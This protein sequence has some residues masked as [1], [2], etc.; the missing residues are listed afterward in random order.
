MILTSKNPTECQNAVVLLRKTGRAFGLA[1]DFLRG[2]ACFGFCGKECRV[3]AVSGVK[4]GGVARERI[5]FG[6]HLQ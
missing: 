5:S 3:G 4:L 6:T 2:V 1:E